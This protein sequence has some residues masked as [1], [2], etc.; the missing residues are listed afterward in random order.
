MKYNLPEALQITKLKTY[1]RTTAINFGFGATALVAVL[2]AQF[3]NADLPVILTLIGGLIFLPVAWLYFTSDYKKVLAA[4][5]EVNNGEFFIQVDGKIRKRIPLQS[6][7]LST[8]KG[9]F[10]LEANQGVAI[11]PEGIENM[12]CLLEEINSQVR[13]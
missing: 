9:G 10:K 12:E 2:F 1:K 5:Y 4:A 8:V 13:R 11:I 6:A 3:K 7:K